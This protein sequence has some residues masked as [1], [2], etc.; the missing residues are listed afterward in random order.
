MYIPQDHHHWKVLPA[1]FVSF[2]VVV[3]FFSILPFVNRINIERSIRVRGDLSAFSL[4]PLHAKETSGFPT[5]VRREP[6]GD[7]PAAI[8][9]QA[10]EAP[11]RKNLLRLEIPTLELARP[12]EHAKVAFV[13]DVSDLDFTPLPIHRVPPDYP[14]SLKQQGVEGSAYVEFRVDK[15]GAVHDVVVLEATHPEFGLSVIQAV[16]RWRFLP[17]MVRGEAVSFRMR[18]PV[19]FRLIESRARSE[20]Y[21]VATHD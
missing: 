19:T 8:G 12:A 15:K 2:G 3:V 4:T 11:P 21:S 9:E 17:G 16:E 5:S 13:F 6:L 7:I 1:T 18:L 10:E 20:P 14:S